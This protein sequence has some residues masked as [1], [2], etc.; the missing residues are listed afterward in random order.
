MREKGFPGLKTGVITRFIGKDKNL[1][2]YHFQGLAGL[3]KAY[4]REKDY[5][6]PFFERFSLSSEVTAL[7]AERLFIELMKENLRFFHG[8]LEMQKII[9]WQISEEN[10]LLQSISEAREADGAKL[11]ELTDPF[12]IH[13]DVNFRSVIA[14]LLGGVYYMVLH[15]NTNKSVVCGINVNS[16]KDRSDVL[17]TIGQIV[18]WSF[19]QVDG[20][21]GPGHSVEVSTYEFALLENLASRFS[22]F[23]IGGRKDKVFASSFIAE[24]ERVRGLLIARLIE[25]SDPM[26]LSSFVKV[27]LFR[28]SSIADGLYLDSEHSHP[29][30]IS[31]MSLMELL[32]VS[33]S[34]YVPKELVLPKILWETEHTRLNGFTIDLENLVKAFEIDLELDEVIMMPLTNFRNRRDEAD[35]GNLIYLKKY[36]AGLLEPLAKSSQGTEEV[37]RLLISLNRNDSLFFEYCVSLITVKLS[38]LS[39]AVRNEFLLNEQI[40]IRQI[41]VIGHTFDRSLKSIDDQLC[42]WIEAE[43]LRVVDAPSVLNENPL[44]FITGLKAVEI[45]YLMKLLYDQNV[46]GELKLDDFVQQVAYNFGTSSQDVLSPSS[47]KSKLY[48]K[49]GAVI[50]VVEKLLVDIL[51]ELRKKHQ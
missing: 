12:F 48:P 37:L 33:F 23:V 7:E 45:A 16:E 21:L 4:I 9:L 28:L 6:P 31:V 40:K 1:I 35:F 20:S 2:R 3:Q 30:S 32:L 41:Q 14:L 17:R 46:F 11:L 18:S 43:L 51:S 29:E 8:D 39:S 42:S 36:I 38:G 24:I 13:T 34:E 50:G 26:Q 15:A 10:P 44:K 19:K 22:G 47:I 27:C 49:D 25:C 5:W